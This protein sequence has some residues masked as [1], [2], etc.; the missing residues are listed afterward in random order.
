[1]TTAEH[2]VIIHL[3]LSDGASGSAIDFAKAHSLELLLE[4]A[5]NRAAAGELDGNEVGGGEFVIYTYG[6]DATRLFG[7]MEPVLRAE[8]WSPG[9]HIVKRYGPPGARQE[10]VPLPV[11]P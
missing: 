7:A 8:P 10:T 11:P 5:I 3:R 4:G 2:A 1:M 6:S 9:G